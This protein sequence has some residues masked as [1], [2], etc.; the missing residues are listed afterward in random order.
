MLKAVTLRLG[1]LKR[2]ESLQIPDVKSLFARSDGVEVGNLNKAV[3]LYNIGTKH[4]RC[5]HITNP[6]LQNELLLLVPFVACLNKELEY[7]Q[8]RQ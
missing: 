4:H 8:E 6:D 2:L 7:L 5:P 1:L 3:R